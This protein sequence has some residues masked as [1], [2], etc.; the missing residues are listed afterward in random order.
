MKKSKLVKSMQFIIIGCAVCGLAMYFYG[1]PHIGNLLVKAYPEYS[2]CYIPWLS[3]L[4]LTGIPCFAVLLYVWKIIGTISH[5]TVFR[6]ENSRRFRSVS[7]WAAGDAAF[8]VIGNLVFL[9][10]NWN[11]PSVLLACL[12][13]SF[14]GW[15]V[16]VA[17]QA[18]ALLTDDAANLQEQSDL[19]I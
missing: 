16:A 9:F 15:A 14:F 1:L 5:N 17:A 7:H 19:T 10:L 13:I 18:L 11:H 2:P 3:F 12:G 6:K 4:W 8:L